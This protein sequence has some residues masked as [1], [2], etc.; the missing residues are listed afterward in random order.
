M[1]CLSTYLTAFEAFH[2]PFPFHFSSLVFTLAHNLIMVNVSPG[3]TTQI[4]IR[5]AF[6]EILDGKGKVVKF[7]QKKDT[8]PPV[9]EGKG[10]DGN[11]YLFS[12]SDA[13]VGVSVV[14]K[15]EN[16]KELRRRNPGLALPKEEGQKL[17]EEIK[18]ENEE[19]LEKEGAGTTSP[20]SESMLRRAN[21]DD[22][23]ASKT[24]E[25]LDKEKEQEQQKRKVR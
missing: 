11:L 19:R 17:D 2:P 21:L 22:K 12:L 5:R 7:E 3:A 8:N 24:P 25:Q 20:E 1:I 23:G 6:T 14:P 18:K 10:T 4:D 13:L 16:N 15:V 9:F